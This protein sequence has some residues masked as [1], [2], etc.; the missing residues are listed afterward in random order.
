MNY[1]WLFDAEDENGDRHYLAEEEFIGSYS[2]AVAR[3][4]ILADEWE[5][6]TG[7]LILRLELERRG[8]AA[9]ELSAAH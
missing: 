7:G 8:K 1:R 6:R 2:E 5:Q 9:S 4:D 3:A